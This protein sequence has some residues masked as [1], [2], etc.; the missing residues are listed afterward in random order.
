MKLRSS[1]LK[2]GEQAPDFTL[3]DQNGDEVT[4]SELL[5]DGPV[6]VFFYPKAFTPV[7]TAEVCGF[8]DAFEEFA[9]AGARI[10]GIS[11]DPVEQQK[12]FAE[13]HAVSFPLLSDVK[14]EV[15]GAFGLRASS[16]AQLMN[17]RVTFVI[18]RDGRVRH[19]ASGMLASEPHV[20]ESL[21]VLR[22][23]ENET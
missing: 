7:C 3:P 20:K 16:K 2:D 19:H 4:L 6:I 8:R 5:A 18:D 23:L 17:D 10:V 14:T 12:S 1:P 11:A 13:K 9:D 22:R 15:Y 21:E